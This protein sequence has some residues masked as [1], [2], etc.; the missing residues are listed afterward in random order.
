MAQ[1]V[2]V[3]CSCGQVLPGGVKFCS[4]CGKKARKPKQE[5][6]IPAITFVKSDTKLAFSA[7]EAAAAIGISVYT[8][9]ELMK[10]GVI[11]YVQIGERRQ[12]IRREALEAYLLKNEVNQAVG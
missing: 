10:Q 2:E 8:V 1:T 11:P 9:Y 5:K 3:K 12:V 6:P 4:A 7:K